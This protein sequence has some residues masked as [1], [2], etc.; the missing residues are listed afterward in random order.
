MGREILNIYL[1]A[2]LFLMESAQ[3][4]IFMICIGRVEATYKPHR[5]YFSVP[6]NAND[7]NFR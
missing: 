7:S 6:V 4:E 1:N 5:L 2:T 3:V